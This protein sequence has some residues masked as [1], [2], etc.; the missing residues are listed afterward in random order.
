MIF[1][2]LLVAFIASIAFFM[3]V[4]HVNQVNSKLKNELMVIFRDACITENKSIPS[5]P[6]LVKDGFQWYIEVDGLCIGRFFKEESEG[7]YRYTFNFTT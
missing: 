3:F 4:V 2:Y 1:I 6:V 7:I 5:Y